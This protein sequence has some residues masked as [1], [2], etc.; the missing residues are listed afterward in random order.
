[1]P[2][3]VQGYNADPLLV[4]CGRPVDLGRNKDGT[5]RRIWVR[6]FGHAYDARLSALR[7][8]AGERACQKDP[9]LDRECQIVT[10]AELIL[11]R[12]DPQGADMDAWENFKGADGTTYPPTLE[13]KKDMLRGGLQ[14]EDPNSYTRQFFL[15]VA[16]VAGEQATF[17]AEEK[18]AAAK[19]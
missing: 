7:K 5:M 11:C 3:D 1:M 18:E 12:R 19:N 9:E 13:H 15:D 17:V 10:M 4:K 2:L 6:P 8:N 14:G 16:T